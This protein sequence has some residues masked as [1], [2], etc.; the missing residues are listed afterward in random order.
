MSGKYYLNRIKPPL[1]IAVFGS[2][3]SG[4]SSFLS[5]LKGV[6]Y[7]GESTRYTEVIKYT[8]P[9]GRRLRFYDCPGQT[10][11]RSERTLLKT[12]I[13]EGKFHAIINVVCY[14]Y[15]ETSN[16]E[17]KV[18]N[19]DGNIRNQFLEENREFELEQLNEWIGDITAS[20]K[21]KWILTLIN[22]EDIWNHQ[23]EEVLSYY[24]S[25]TYSKLFEGISKVCPVHTL[26]Y[27]SV[28]DL[29]AGKP[30]M[31]YFTEKD[32]INRHISLIDNLCR[33]IQKSK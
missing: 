17:V 27:C 22:K 13:L 32:K 19:S 2:S 30:M 25:Q 8:L 20:S 5:M 12:A 23:K 4:K 3:G 1:K 16:M 24:K 7:E 11:Y 21:L 31:Q 26:T 14:G 6:R 28:M 29:F 10:S 15:N 18:F 33:Y 9:D